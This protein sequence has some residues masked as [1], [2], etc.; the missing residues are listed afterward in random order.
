MTIVSQLC[1]NGET[2]LLLKTEDGEYHAL[3]VIYD[4]GLAVMIAAALRGVLRLKNTAGSIGHVDGDAYTR[5][6]QDA[7]RIAG[8]EVLA[9]ALNNLATTG[10]GG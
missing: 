5:G 3:G 6:M 10:N 1:T 4:A 9:E 7:N 2:G 8:G